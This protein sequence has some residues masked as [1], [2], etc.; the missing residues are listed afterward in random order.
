MNRISEAEKARQL[1]TLASREKI[2][3]LLEH[4]LKWRDR[5]NDEDTEDESSEDEDETQTGFEAQQNA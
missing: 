5:V 1:A 4:E 3:V 2:P